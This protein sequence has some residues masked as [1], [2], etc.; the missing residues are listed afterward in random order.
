MFNHCKLNRNATFYIAHAIASFQFVANICSPKFRPWV[1]ATFDKIFDAQHNILRYLCFINVHALAA[2]HLSQHCSLRSRCNLFVQ[3]TN[4][5]RNA[6]PQ[7]RFSLHD[8]CPQKL[9]YERSI[10]SAGG[11][12]QSRFLIYSLQ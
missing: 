12:Y 1:F 3:T 7:K 11:L 8:F 9:I 4:G 10:I 6:R 5:S 2:S